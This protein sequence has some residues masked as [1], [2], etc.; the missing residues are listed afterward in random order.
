MRA[1]QSLRE[2]V[3]SGANKISQRPLWQRRVLLSL[4]IGFLVIGA[5]LI[6]GRFKNAK[7]VQA[8]ISVGVAKASLGDISVY[9]DELGTVT[10]YYTVNIQPRVSGQIMRVDVKEGQY[11]HAGQELALIDPRPYQ[12]ALD[13]AQG[14]LARDQ[15]LLT[16]AKLDLE[17]YKKL[18]AEDAIPSQEYDT[19]IATVGQDEGNVESDQAAVETAKL[20]LI[21]AHV[22]SPI[23]GR[24]GLRLV[25]PGNVIYT[26][27]ANGANTIFVVT[28]MR[29]ITVVFTLPEEDI[30]S[31]MK[32][33]N[34]LKP[35]EKLIVDAFSRDGS[36]KLE[37]G[38]LLALDSGIQVNTGTL[39]LKAEF[40]N[41]EGMLYPNEF[42][43]ARLYLDTERRQVIIP[44]AAVQS[45]PD[46]SFVY[47]VDQNNTVETRSVK[48]GIANGNNVSIVDGLQA[49]ETVVTDGVDF[50]RPGSKVRVASQRKKDQKFHKKGSQ[51][52]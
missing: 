48:V 32:R 50:I 38:T 37:R 27:T 52:E 4:T 17:R 41:K 15:A 40:S 3:S 11:V 43:N 33:L 25:D 49:G 12:A 30:P 13:Q 22:T 16:D 44:A 14:A 36:Q 28:K 51:N 1:I 8:G 34:Q 2:K 42:V 19:Q 7:H 29:P 10:A 47:V 24:V 31:L 26:T 45:G 21:Y 46:G 6:A 39:N 35:G 23:D 20:N 9:L 5:L 18:L